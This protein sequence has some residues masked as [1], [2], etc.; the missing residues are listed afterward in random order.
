MLPLH[1]IPRRS[2]LVP[3]LYRLERAD[4]ESRR[5]L[6][7][8]PRGPFTLY[9]RSLSFGEPIP[10]VTGHIARFPISHDVPMSTPPTVAERRAVVINTLLESG[11]K[12]ATPTW[13]DFMKRNYER[14][15][16]YA[17]TWLNKGKEVD[18]RFV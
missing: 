18:P 13:V 8:Y 17:R 7:D 14:I 6:E 11:D 15:R 4:L 5:E 1:E 10:S 2:D 16:R 9:D 3:K 12:P